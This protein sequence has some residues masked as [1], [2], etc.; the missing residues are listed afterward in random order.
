MVE[1]E[2]QV[3]AVQRADRGKDHADDSK[4]RGNEFGLIEQPND[5][6][7]PTSKQG[8][9]EHENENDEWHLWTF[10]G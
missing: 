9:G 4:Q 5:V 1:L 3:D 10:R 6:V 7:D 2:E 8:Q